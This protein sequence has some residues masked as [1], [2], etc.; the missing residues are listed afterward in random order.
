MY[1]RKFF[2]LSLYFLYSI[3][4][5]QKS[6]LMLI[7]DHGYFKSCLRFQCFFRKIVSKVN[8]LSLYKAI[9]TFDALG[10]MLCHN[11]VG[12]GENAGHERQ[13][14]SYFDGTPTFLTFINTA[15]YR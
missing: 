1:W 4:H 11:I 12:K 8:Q 2:P 13:I 14:K 6:Q 7:I 15:T 5:E 10:Q 9:T 3:I